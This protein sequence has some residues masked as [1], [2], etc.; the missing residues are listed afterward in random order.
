M[1]QETLFFITQSQQL[2]QGE[3]PSKFSG[4]I[5]NVTQELAAGLVSRRAHQGSRGPTGRTSRRFGDD[6]PGG[7]L[8][9][10]LGSQ[11][12]ARMLGR[13]RT[14][15]HWGRGPAGTASP[16]L[17]CPMG[18]P[19][20]ASLAV[21]LLILRD[22]WVCHLFVFCSISA[23][24]TIKMNWEYDPFRIRAF[25]FQVEG[26]TLQKKKNWEYIHPLTAG[27]WKGKYFLCS[28]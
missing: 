22:P 16:Q 24:S 19:S 5:A 18:E 17:P 9:T 27:A 28:L 6:K 26:F 14:R 20:C 23:Q 21:A 3:F 15:P 12:G 10:A 1:S 13:S 2:Q 8:S 7:V 11:P 4:K 25:Y